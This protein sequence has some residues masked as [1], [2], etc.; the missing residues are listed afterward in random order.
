V[1]GVD[2]VLLHDAWK[3]RLLLD[4]APARQAVPL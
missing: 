2:E 3:A 4:T 1:E